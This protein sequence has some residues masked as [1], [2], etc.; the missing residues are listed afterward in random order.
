MCESNEIC[1]KYHQTDN[2]SWTAHIEEG[3]TAIF[4]NDG[5]YHHPK[6]ASQFRRLEFSKHFYYG[7]ENVDL[8]FTYMHY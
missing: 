4:R 3:S 5:N 2:L 7:T 1:N 6:T 8:S